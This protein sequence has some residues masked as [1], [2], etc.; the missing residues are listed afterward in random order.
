MIVMGQKRDL[1]ALCWEAIAEQIDMHARAG[2]G[3]ICARLLVQ[4]EAAGVREAQRTCSL[5]G[6]LLELRLHIA[7]AQTCIALQDLRAALAHLDRGGEL[8]RQLHRGR[9]DII[10]Q[11]LL[12]QVRRGL[13]EDTKAM[14]DEAVSLA[15]THGLRRVLRDHIARTATPGKRRHATVDAADATFSEGQSAS[16]ARESMIVVPSGLLTPKEREVLQFLA[17][18]WS[19]KAIANA[20]GGSPETVKWHV[21]NLFTKLDAS[22][23]RHLIDRARQIGILQ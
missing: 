18:S 10:T 3:K 17:Q 1:P 14:L 20:L 21:K 8:A 23:R 5:L 15:N 4:L 16:P 11:L 13:G 2:R 7:R 19:N 6:P 22:S 12:V 9:E